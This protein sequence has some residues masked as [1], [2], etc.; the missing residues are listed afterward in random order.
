[1]QKQGVAV[2]EDNAETYD[3]WFDEHDLIYQA[4]LKALQR[5]MPTSQASLE[6]GV[7]TGRFASPLGISLGVEPSPAMAR[8]AEARG[9][10]VVCAYGEN[11][12]F[13]DAQFDVALLVTVL[14]FVEDISAVLREVKRVL[15]PGGQIVIAM[16][17]PA[18]PLVQS[19]E[20][21]QATS[22]F[23]RDAHFHS[24]QAIVDFLQEA[25]FADF[26]FCQSVFANQ[27]EQAEQPTVL[28]GYGEGAFVVIRAISAART[29]PLRSGESESQLKLGDSYDS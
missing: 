6:I 18:S 1:M 25:G 5:L 16:I 9:I 26:A 13:P 2:F 3:R 21:R 10:R 4:E 27:T 14:C 8:I 11:L 12:P 29:A 7:G 23:Y 15:Q 22:T 17:D 19:Y 28:D 24:V 20:Q